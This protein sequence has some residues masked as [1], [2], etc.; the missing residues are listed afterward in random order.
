M[1]T[2]Y[3]TND[4]QTHKK[5][6]TQNGHKAYIGYMTQGVF[7]GHVNQDCGSVVPMSWTLDGFVLGA[8]SGFDL[9]HP[10]NIAP[11]LNR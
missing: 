5:Y 4:Y 9:K 2:K 7:I 8:D 3:E 10:I 6:E 11:Q 1:N